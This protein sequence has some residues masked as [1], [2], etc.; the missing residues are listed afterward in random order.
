MDEHPGTKK[1]AF[2]IIIPVLNEASGINSLIR[3][4]ENQQN[5]HSFEII[6]VD[7]DPDGQTINAITN[8]NVIKI[9]SSI[10]RA[11][12]MN[13]AAAITNAD[14]LIFLHADTLLPD[15]ALNNIAEEFENRNYVAGAFDFD[16][17]SKKPI[18]KIIAACAC[19]RSRLTRI[20]YGDQ[21][22]FIR[23]GYFDTIGRF[24]EL[25]LMED[26]ELIKRIK[27]RGDKIIILKAR[28]KTSSRRWEKEGVI[29]TTLR[30]RLISF[31]YMLGVSPAKLVKFYRPHTAKGS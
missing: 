26:I 27:K 17:D 29:Y 16:I 20:P 13:C 9:K 2:A 3:Q 19:I 28:V 18:V 6:V 15:N 22:I 1:S 30:N 12:Q 4:L 25:P 14:T 7:G 24:K 8:E 11:K 10:G 23:K 31:L 5:K 21:A